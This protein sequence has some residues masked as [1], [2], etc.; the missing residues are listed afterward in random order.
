MKGGT[1]SRRVWRKVYL[2]RLLGRVSWTNLQEYII[3]EYTYT[4]IRHEV[5]KTYSTLV[6]RVWT[7]RRRG[8]QPS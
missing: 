2:L 8:R 5:G 4:R 1:K 6:P 3:V 7:A